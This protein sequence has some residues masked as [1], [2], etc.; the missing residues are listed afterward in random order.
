MYDVTLFGN[1]ARWAYKNIHIWGLPGVMVLAVLAAIQL[2]RRVR[3]RFG[4]IVLPAALAMVVLFYLAAF[5]RLPHE[6]SYLIPILFICVYLMTCFYSSKVPYYL[7]AAAF[8]F[9]AFV[10][11]DFLRIDYRTDVPGRVAKGANVE[12]HVKRGVLL[13]DLQARADE[14]EL[15]KTHAVISREKYEKP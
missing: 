8:L 9:N 6:I 7:L 4:N 3:P 12:L 13:E 10:R 14:E 11:V 15:M 2:K 1:A 5:F